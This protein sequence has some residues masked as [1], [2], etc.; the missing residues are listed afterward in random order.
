LLRAAAHERAGGR[1]L[2]IRVDYALRDLIQAVHT[3]AGYQ[4]GDELTLP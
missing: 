2:P 4:D 3:D 1:S